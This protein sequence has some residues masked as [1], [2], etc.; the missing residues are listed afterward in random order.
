[1]TKRVTKRPTK[2]LTKAE[3]LA[4]RERTK[5]RADPPSGALVGAGFL[6]AMV[7]AALA[8]A[9][10]AWV[11]GGYGIVSGVTLVAYGLDKRAAQAQAERMPE[12][13]L[14]ALGLAGGWPGALIASRL[15][16]HKSVKKPFR[17]VLWF[18]VVA[19]LVLLAGL[20]AWRAGALAR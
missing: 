19:N 8:D 9:V 17:A 1:M 16:R 10:P 12:R 13:S 14:H 20:L 11:A 5:R 15:W 4:E 6:V 3:K 18:T 7:A 2:R